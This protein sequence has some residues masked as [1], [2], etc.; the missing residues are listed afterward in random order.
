MF[1]S[2][3]S[4]NPA[5]GE[6]DLGKV[7]PGKY[8]ITYTLPKTELTSEIKKSTSIVIENYPVANISYSR[9]EK[10]KNSIRFLLPILW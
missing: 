1:S 10:L 6:I 7:Q 5:T 4:V 2:T 9:N 8:I 3:I